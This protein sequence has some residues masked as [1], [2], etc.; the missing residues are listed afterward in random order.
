MGC[1][2]DKVNR[3]I[4]PA[5]AAGMVISW[6]QGLPQEDFTAPQIAYS[7]TV[8]P[9]HLLF[10]LNTPNRGKPVIRDEPAIGRTSG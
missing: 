3:V 7:A 9:G 1:N 4:L 5:R 2:D 6:F 10:R 8:G